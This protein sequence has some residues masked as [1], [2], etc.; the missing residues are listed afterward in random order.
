MFNFRIFISR[1]TDPMDPLLPS[2]FLTTKIDQ[3]IHF[4]K[5]TKSVDS[6]Q[7]MHGKQSVI[8]GAKNWIQNLQKISF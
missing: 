8:K 7:Q 6:H 5:H 3:N 1:T 4:D 2:L